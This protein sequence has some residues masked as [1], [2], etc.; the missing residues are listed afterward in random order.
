M[1]DDI[2]EKEACV[3]LKMQWQ[4]L[5]G[6]GYFRKALINR[7]ESIIFERILAEKKDCFVVKIEVI[8]W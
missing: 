2:C 7:S 4:S 3:Q 8:A 5:F 6:E 1:D